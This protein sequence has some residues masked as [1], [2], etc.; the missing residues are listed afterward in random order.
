LTVHSNGASV[1]PPPTAQ[2]NHDDEPAPPPR[3]TLDQLEELD[4]MAYWRR[5][6]QRQIDNYEG[7]IAEAM[8]KIQPIV[9]RRDALIAA[10]EAAGGKTISGSAT[11]RVQ[12]PPSAP[13]RRPGAAPKTTGQGV[14]KRYPPEKIAEVKR[15]IDQGKDNPTISAATGVAA[16]TVSY[17]RSKK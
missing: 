16:S 8:A 14:G 3:S 4:P 10:L 9:E 13:G 11:R 5:M 17:Y 7:Q 2:A 1:P 15:L 12:L 6:T